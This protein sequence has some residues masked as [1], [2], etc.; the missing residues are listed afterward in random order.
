MRY[1]LIF[2]N[3]HDAL[4]CEK[5]LSEIS[6]NIMVLPTPSNIANSC[7]ISIGIDYE[8]IDIVD[9]LIEQGKILIKSI[10]D[11][12]EEQIIK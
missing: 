5:I 3:T 8:S 7:G 12:Y 6:I 2:I 1:I 11:V 9:K 10:Y 4:K